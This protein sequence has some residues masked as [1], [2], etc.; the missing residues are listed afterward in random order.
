MSDT[1]WSVNYQKFNQ[2]LDENGRIVATVNKHESLTELKARAD[3]IAATP[4]LLNFALMY[5][6]QHK[7][8]NSEMMNV[9]KTAV[10]KAIP[11][12]RFD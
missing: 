10:L 1:S 9:A 4:D 7:S 5:I 3:L 6:E 2:V 12:K 11:K 8:E